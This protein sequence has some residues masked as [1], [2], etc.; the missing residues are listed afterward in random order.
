MTARAP[1]IRN[2][3]YDD[4]YSLMRNE[5][6]N[7]YDITFR[8]RG[9]NVCIIAPHG[10][11]I[12]PRTERIARKVA[13][14]EHSFFIFR[15]MNNQCLRGFS[16]HVTSTKFRH[17][18]LTRILSHCGIVVTIHGKA[19]GINGTGPILIGGLN[20][21]FKEIMLADLTNGGFAAQIAVQ[22]ELAGT[23][24]RNICNQGRHGSKPGVQLEIPASLRPR[25]MSAGNLNTIANAIRNAIRH[26]QKYLGIQYENRDLL[27]SIEERSDQ[28][29]RHVNR[30]R[31]LPPFSS[32]INVGRYISS[33][34]GLR[35]FRQFR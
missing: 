32:T 26:Y 8:D 23:D 3:E 7:C 18:D 4:L 6:S 21:K 34:F 14:S 11:T 19:D 30:S 31:A 20:T 33:S 35:A 24:P 2:N 12:E 5:P 10:G 29:N 1:I 13:G 27:R 28:I 16:R 17:H 9:G 15:S 22:G 25:G